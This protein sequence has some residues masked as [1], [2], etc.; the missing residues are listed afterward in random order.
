M[1]KLD[2]IDY[3]ELYGLSV[4]KENSELFFNDSKHLYVNK[5]DGSHYISVT[6]LIGEYENK[7]DEAFWSKYKALELFLDGD[8]WSN[9]KIKLGNTKK[10]DPNLLTLYNINEEDFNKEVD[11][12]LAEWASNRNEACEHGTYVH[13]LYENSFYGN[14]QFD[15]G[16]YGYPEASGYYDCPRNYY[17][18]DLENAIYPEFLMSWTSPD[19]ELKIAGQ[20][21]LICK[22]GNDIWILD[23]KTN[24]EIKKRSFYDKNKKDV[25][26]MLYPL[27]DLMDCNYQ[28]YELQL[29][30]YAWILQQIRPEFNIKGLSIIHI[31]RNSGRQTEYPLEY[32][33]EHVEKMIKHYKHQLMIKKQLDRLEPY[34]IG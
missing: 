31:D 15:L 19:G 9:V 33:K 29:S 2:G 18:L 27:N 28:H 24:K 25:Q 21:D 6:T 32:R 4:D 1:P 30:T 20:S 7:F 5:N 17:E 16:K 3:K 23:W 22:R 12:I 14:T 10:W 26:R 13:S 8:V 11:K 34:K